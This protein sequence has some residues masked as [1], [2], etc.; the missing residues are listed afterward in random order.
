VNGLIIHSDDFGETNEITRGIVE[1]IEASIVTST[2]ILANMPGTETAIAEAA[3]R[4]R[5]ASF[6]VH[7]NLCEGSPLTKPRSLTGEDGRF[8][9]KREVA[10]AAATGRL[11]PDE[12]SVEIEAQIARIHDDGVQVS[13]LDSHKHLH[14]LPGVSRVV[15]EAA[16]KFGIERIRCTLEDGLWARG[17]RPVAALS[18]A[19]RM[20]FAKRARSHFAEAGL[21]HP[22]RVFDVRELMAYPDRSARLALLRSPHALSEMFCHVGTELADREKPGSCDRNAELRFLLSPEFKTLLDEAPLKLKTFWDC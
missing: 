7:L 8:L 19:V 2:S 6:G 18:R 12:L 11:D 4:G 20:R 10:L 16:R 9:G 21:R 17:L 1:G 3:R 15:A 14:Q 5:E 22:G 13:H